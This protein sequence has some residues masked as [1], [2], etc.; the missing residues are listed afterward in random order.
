MSTRHPQ[1]RQ[2][3]QRHQLRGVLGQ[4]TEAHL[5]VSEL[6]L[7]HPKR[8][9]NLG[10]HLRLGLFDPALGFVHGTAFIEFLVGATTSRDLS[11]DCAASML[12]A[13]FNAGVAR[14]G[15]DDALVTVS[16]LS[17]W[18]TSATLAAVPTTLCT[19]PDS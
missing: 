17:T 11:D 8:V 19:S 15:A 12:G 3:E 1:V 7:D 14:I 10:P 13:L 6:A 18:A 9:L 5:H 16:S 4:A 2:C